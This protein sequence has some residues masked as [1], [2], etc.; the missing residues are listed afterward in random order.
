[1]DLIDQITEVTKNVFFPLPV[2][3]NPVHLIQM[4]YKLK[5][6]LNRLTQT[7]RNAFAAS[8]QVHCIR[9]MFMCSV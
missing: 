3:T 9:F 1:M 8:T 7:Q 2:A 4:G 6:N 5:E